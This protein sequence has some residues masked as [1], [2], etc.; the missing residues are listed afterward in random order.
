MQRL[1]CLNGTLGCF[2]IGTNTA[3][4]SGPKHPVKKHYSEWGGLGPVPSGFEK[5]PTREAAGS[6]PDTPCITGRNVNVF[7]IHASC[8]TEPQATNYGSCSGDRRWR[9]KRE[10]K[11]LEIVHETFRT[12]RRYERVIIYSAQTP[13]SPCFDTIFM[14]FYIQY[15]TRVKKG[16]LTF[17][18]PCTSTLNN[19]SWIKN[20]RIRVWFDD[21]E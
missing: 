18:R 10:N 5:D 6:E 8:E 16:S 12:D 11:T 19:H 15:S 13:R 9:I 21:I 2:T 7:K 14:D 4:E 1:V 17:F 20:K 3:L